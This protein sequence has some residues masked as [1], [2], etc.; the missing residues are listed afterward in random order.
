M[1]AP[2]GMKITM[3]PTAG[4]LIR[5]SVIFYP[6]SVCNFKTPALLKKLYCPRLINFVE[7]KRFLN[8][9]VFDLPLI[10]Q[11]EREQPELW[12]QTHSVKI[13]FMILFCFSTSGGFFCKL[14]TRF[15]HSHSF[16]DK[17][18]ISTDRYF[19]KTAVSFKFDMSSC[20]T[21]F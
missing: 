10:N 11:G 4:L 20:R 13:S 16:F 21:C 9:G 7:A 14:C 6:C 5:T 18:H 8:N 1:T 3:T 17:F 12:G 15:R 2:K 19:F